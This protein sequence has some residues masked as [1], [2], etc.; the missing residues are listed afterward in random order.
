MFSF[1][2]ISKNSLATLSKAHTAFETSTHQWTK[3]SVLSAITIARSKK[4]GE[5]FVPFL[6]H[7]HHFWARKAG[8]AFAGLL[9]NEIKA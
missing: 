2:C 7:L 1:Q 5:A 3:S 4:R 8:P 6:K 9:A